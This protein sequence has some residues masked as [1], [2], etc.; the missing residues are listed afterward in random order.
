M[1]YEASLLGSNA[2]NMAT[3]A[4][5]ILVVFIINNFDV[6]SPFEVFRLFFGYFS[7]FDWENQMITIYGTIKTLNF[8][9]RLKTEFNFDIKK[10]ALAER[11]LQM[12]SQSNFKMRE[13]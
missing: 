6:R 5:Y 3:Y 12:L 1:T 10:F 7:K 13:S 4:L 8:Y 11:K 2:A 9:D